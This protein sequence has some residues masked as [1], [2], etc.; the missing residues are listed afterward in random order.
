MTTAL[1]SKEL[2]TALTEENV[3]KIIDERVMETIVSAPGNNAL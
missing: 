1:R 2:V 3:N